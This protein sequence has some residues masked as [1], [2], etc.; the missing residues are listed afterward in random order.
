MCFMANSRFFLDT[1]RVK[2]GSP[3]NLKVAI[4][5][6]KKTAYIPLKAKLFPEQ[7]DT[8]RS[9]VV[10][11]PEEKLLNLYISSVKQ[12]VD[13]TIILLADSGVLKSMD[14]VDIKQEVERRL[15]PEK[16]EEKA[17]SQKHKGQFASRFLAFADAI[18][19]AQA[20]S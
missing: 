11:H 20:E 7:W 13:R 1:R 3:A 17:Q 8:T 16:A 12:Q 9:V 2:P 14:V 10:N 5:H 15:D 4:A 6:L 18:A 19:T